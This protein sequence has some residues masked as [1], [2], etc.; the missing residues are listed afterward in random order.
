MLQ[1]ELG[2]PSKWN[3]DFI[4][5]SLQCFIWDGGL[6]AVMHG[7]GIFQLEIF[8]CPCHVIYVGKKPLNNPLVIIWCYT[9]DYLIGPFSCAC[10][11]INC[12]V[13]VRNADST[14]EYHICGPSSYQF[15]LEKMFN[16]EQTQ[17]IFW[18]G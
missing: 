6:R 7:K 4:Q 17:I 16:T 1:A 10:F 13:D 18:L 14:S 12:I 5:M 3:F 15:I 11:Y 9:P 2:F 8:H